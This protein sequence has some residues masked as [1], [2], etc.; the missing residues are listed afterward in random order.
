[1]HVTTPWAVGQN[2]DACMHAWGVRYVCNGM[3]VHGTTAQ[4]SCQIVMYGVSSVLAATEAQK[5][6]PSASLQAVM[7]GHTGAC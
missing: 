2:M 3:Q 1:M 5:A 6:T 4:L 7:Q